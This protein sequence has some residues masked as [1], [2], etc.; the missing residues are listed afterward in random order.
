MSTITT[1]AININDTVAFRPTTEGLL[2]WKQYQDRLLAQFPDLVKPLSWYQEQ[3]Q[4]DGRARMPLHEFG[5]I[6]GPV[7][8]AHVFQYLEPDLQIEVL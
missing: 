2:L 5:R 7:L 3:V 4:P 1:F 8:T 6:F